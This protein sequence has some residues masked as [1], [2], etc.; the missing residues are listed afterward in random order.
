MV[1][2]ERVCAAHHRR[3]EIRRVFEMYLSAFLTPSSPRPYI[4]N[5]YADVAKLADA[6][7]SE[8]CGSDTVVVQVHSSALK[9]A[10]AKRSKAKVKKR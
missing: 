3:H 6:Q 8:A 2:S 5:G 9:K 1:L 10:K 7:V 4:Q